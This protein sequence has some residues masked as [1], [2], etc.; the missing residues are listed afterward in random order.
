MI[1]LERYRDPARHLEERQ[2]LLARCWHFAGMLYELEGTAHMGVAVA[3]VELLLQRDREGRPRAFRNVCSHR[4][5]QLCGHGVHHRAVRC[6]YHGWVYDREGV[7]VG[8]PQPQAFPAVVADPAAHRLHEYACEAAGQ[9]VFVRIAPEGPG[10]REF[11]GT[12]H[13]FLQRA[14]A[15]MNGTLSEFS[16]EVPANWKVLIENSLEGYHVPA[17]HNQTFMQVD[18]MQSGIEAAQNFFVE[19]LHSHMEHA[20]EPGWLRRFART[21]EPRI[22]RWAWRFGHYTHHH[23]FPNLTVTSFMGYSFHVQVFLPQ[24]VDVTR[25]HS[26]TVGVGFDGQDAYGE[27]F[28]AKIYADNH[29]FT[30]RVFEE[31]GAICARVQAGLAMAERPALFG[32]GIEDRVRHF[33]QA[34]LHADPTARAAAR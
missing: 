6:P 28:I 12:E 26:R 9:F 20:A 33:H 30:A 34:Y 4:H 3:G 21:M 5:S 13:D 17:V 27:K 31:D 32:E 11:L 23:I 10:L 29:A 7:P 8:I 18:G 2:A 15:G 14:S 24:A 1:D 16:E 25:V 22:G 19:P